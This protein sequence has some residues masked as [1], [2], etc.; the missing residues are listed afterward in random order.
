M[1][2][3]VGKWR[4]I[5]EN[6]VKMKAT[7]LKNGGKLWNNEGKWKMEENGGEVKEHDGNLPFCRCFTFSSMFEFVAQITKKHDEHEQ[8]CGTQE[9]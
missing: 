5:M 8:T 4:K 1:E 3:L 2:H 7:C 6:E 9:V